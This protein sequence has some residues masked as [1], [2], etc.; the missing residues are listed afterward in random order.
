MTDVTISNDGVIRLTLKDLTE[1]QAL[2]AGRFVAAYRDAATDGV[3]Q[4]SEVNYWYSKAN[5]AI[6][7]GYA[8]GLH[9]NGGFLAGVALALPDMMQGGRAILLACETPWEPLTTIPAMQAACREW[10]ARRGLQLVRSVRKV[11]VTTTWEAV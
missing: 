8:I 11:E 5:L 7:V 4:A 1:D 9:V 10:A 3:Q 2:E 6:E